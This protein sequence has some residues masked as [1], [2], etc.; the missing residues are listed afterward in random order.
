MG[1]QNATHA[2]DFLAAEHVW[3]SCDFSFGHAPRSAR[4]LGEFMNQPF[5]DDWPFQW[6]CD[7][8]AAIRRFSPITTLSR[9]IF[10]QRVCGERAHLCV[11]CEQIFKHVEKKIIF[12]HIF[13]TD[14]YLRKIGKP[15]RN[16]KIFP[17]LTKTKC[18][19]V[20]VGGWRGRE[21]T[22]TSCR[23]E[24]RHFDVCDHEEDC[25]H[26]DGCYPEEEELG[27][28]F[29]STFI[30][31][32]GWLIWSLSNLLPGMKSWVRALPDS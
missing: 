20:C 25:H 13:K 16:F 30:V 17:M 28:G 9:C 11:R 2:S 8:L 4:E 24:S 19:W 15:S 26:E 32:S 27:G 3:A 18:V 5:H 10:H 1:V 12:S 29:V 14:V 6:T 21:V 22:L 31:P 7:T 23:K